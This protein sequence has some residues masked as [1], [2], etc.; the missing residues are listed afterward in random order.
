MPIVGMVL[1]AAFIK[2]L[3]TTTLYP[4]YMGFLADSYITWGNPLSVSDVF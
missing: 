4:V 1:M 2:G 3:P